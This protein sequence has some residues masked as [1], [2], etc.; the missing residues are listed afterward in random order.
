[1]GMEYSLFRIENRDSQ[2]K[3]EITVRII[4]VPKLTRFP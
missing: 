3:C 1:M 2:G 4:S